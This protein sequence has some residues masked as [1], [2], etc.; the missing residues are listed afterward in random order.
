MNK[1]TI[2]RSEKTLKIS[3]RSLFQFELLLQ[4]QISCNHVKAHTITWLKVL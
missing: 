3:S 2:S 4:P 1:K